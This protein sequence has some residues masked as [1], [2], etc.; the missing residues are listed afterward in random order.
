M[1]IVTVA[2]KPC[3]GGITQNVLRHSCGALH[4]D[5]CRVGYVSESDKTPTV[6]RGTFERES[7]VGANF[8]HHKRGWGQWIVNHAGRWPAN[9][10]LQ[11]EGAAAI[12]DLQS[13]HQVSRVHVGVSE[14]RKRS[15]I[16]GVMRTPEHD[17][18]Y[19]DAGGASRYFKQVRS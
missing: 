19:A 14:S 13:G 12:L 7:G 5:A 17:A 4:V 2:R 8:P 3:D 18:G 6:G 10:I 1:K 15:E 16:Y 9:V 11:G